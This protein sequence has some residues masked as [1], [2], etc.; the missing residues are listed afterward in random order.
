LNKLNGKSDQRKLFCL[1]AYFG[2]GKNN[3]SQQQGLPPKTALIVQFLAIK[4][5]FSSID[6]KAFE[7]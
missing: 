7:I 1:V 4:K 2:Q 6:L 3:W 5:A